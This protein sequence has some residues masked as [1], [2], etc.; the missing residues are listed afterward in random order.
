MK[1]T[2]HIKAA[3]GKTLFSLEI[4]PP[5]K[6]DSIDS[7]FNHI[8]PLMEFKPPFIDVTY[9]REEYVY[10]NRG[11]GLLEKKTIRKRPGTVGICAAIKNRYNVDPVPHIICGGFTKEETENALIDLN[12]LGIDNVLVLRGDSIAEEKTFKP[13]P[14]GNAY[15]IDLVDQVVGMNEGQYLD[16]DLQNAVPTTFCIGVAG[17][18]EKHFEAPN[19][20]SDLKYLKQ[21]I[22]HGAEY[23][24]T[25]MFFDNQKYFE[26][27]DKCREAGINVP[28][29][30]GLKPITA[31]SHMTILPSIFHIDIPDELYTEIEKCKDNKQVKEVGIEWGIKQSK[32]LMA[33][34]VPVL[35]Y[36]SMGK[37][38]SVERIAKSL[39]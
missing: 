17:Y 29:I 7:L 15:A 31:K 2:E 19:L 10:K 21:K 32:E 16:E 1:V 4:I 8:D 28:I 18:P 35:H 3:E 39:F 11:N 33:A 36:Y 26:F 9:H 22:D 34:G 12:F 27:V 14:D 5:K 25:Q 38:D 23:I 30:P 6:G 13:E 24:V 20:T 37:S